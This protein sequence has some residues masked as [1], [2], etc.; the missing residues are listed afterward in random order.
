MLAAR[1]Q[2]RSASFSAGGRGADS[3]VIKALCDALSFDATDPAPLSSKVLNEEVGPDQAARLAA[4]AALAAP[5]PGQETGTHQVVLL[6]PQPALMTS[7]KPNSAG[8]LSSIQS[9]LAWAPP[10]WLENLSRPAGD[11]STLGGKDQ[12]VP[13]GIVCLAMI[14]THSRDPH[15]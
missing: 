8:R 1:R 4:L 11:K 12:P 14:V 7:L 13:S 9:F 15:F 10:A 3:K 6:A 2:N 5:N